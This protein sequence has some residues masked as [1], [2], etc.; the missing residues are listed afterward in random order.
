MSM[1]LPRP[2]SVAIALVMGWVPL[3]ADTVELINGDRLTGTIR[4]LEEGELVLKTEYLGV[5]RI[6]WNDIASIESDSKFSILT[7]AGKRFDGRLSKREEEVAVTENGEMVATLDSP[8]VAR[9]VP[10]RPAGGG[11]SLLRALTGAAD[12]GYS[13]ARG[14]QNQ[15]QSSLGAR[16]SYGSARHKFSARLDSIFS[17]QDDARSQSRH[18]L[19][20]RLD[21]FMNERLFAYGLAGLERNERRRLDLR[22]RIGAGIGWRL[23]KSDS[24]SFAL[25]G[26]MA[27]V[28]ERFRHEANRGAGESFLGFEWDAEPFK[29][30]EVVTQLTFHPDV[31]DAHN[32]RMELDSELRVPISRRLTY[33]L[34]FFDRFD[35]T[36][37]IGIERNDY[38]LVSG[39]GVTF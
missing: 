3:Q 7:N 8:T 35:T 18:A 10:G 9:I 11:A 20:A 23:N 5:L 31:L 1:C 25:L 34:R 14:N 26:G 33:T 37:A 24:T 2:K 4:Q 12:I 16:A 29:D 17:K 36:P 28:H 27:Y 19:N 30:V 13:L 39:V 38:G 21:R 15:M 22:S 6:D 32:L